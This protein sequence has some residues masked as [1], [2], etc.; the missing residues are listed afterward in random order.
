MTEIPTPAPYFPASGKFR[1]KPVVVEA[2]RW[3]GTVATWELICEMMGDSEEVIFL[4]INNTLDVPTNHGRVTASDGDWIIKTE[5]GEFYPCN[6][7]I[8]T[9]YYE[10]VSE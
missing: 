10:P 5:V 7:G 9:A 2:V 8:F 4:N 6:D 1:K 3:D